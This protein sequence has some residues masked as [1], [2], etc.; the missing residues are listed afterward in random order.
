MSLQVDMAEPKGSEAAIQQIRSVLSAAVTGAGAADGLPTKQH[1][2]VSMPL[3]S[4]EAQACPLPAPA[5]EAP[6][7]IRPNLERDTL[8]QAAEPCTGCIRPMP[9]FVDHYCSLLASGNCG[10]AP[11]KAR[12]RFHQAVVPG[13]VCIQQLPAVPDCT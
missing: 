6:V 12:P 13:P 7:L 1:A 2:H 9:L 4:S 3:V 8:F 10:S 11:D 5:A